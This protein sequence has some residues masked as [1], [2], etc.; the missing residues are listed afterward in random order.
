MVGNH[1]D[2]R[3]LATLTTEHLP[4][5]AQR[6]AALDVSV[7]LLT[8]RWFL[9][10]WSS[11]LPA[12][13]LS[14]LW[15]FLFV[16]GPQAT[17]QA[18]L[19]CM[20]LVEQPVLASRD[21]GEALAAVKEGL[22]LAADGT[23]LMRVALSRVAQVPRAQLLA[24]R[25]HCRQKVISEARHVQATR[26]LL[27]LQRSSG[28]SLEELKLMARLSGPFTLTPID[29]ATALLRI[30]LDYDAFVG[31]LKGLVPQW[32]NDGVPALALAN[33]GA[34]GGGNGSGSGSS[35]SGSG[36]GAAAAASLMRRLFCLF[37]A[38][39]ADGR[40]EVD[41]DCDRRDGRHEVDID[42]DRRDGLDAL[43]HIQSAEY[44]V[45]G[46][47]EPSATRSAAPASDAE[48]APPP[49]QRLSFEQL[50]HGLS[51]LLRGTSET[52][53]QLCFRA[54][55]QAAATPE[56]RLP[57]AAGTVG[58]ERFREILT[59]V[60]VMYEPAWPVSAEAMG[61][62]GAEA[63]QFTEIAFEL[64]DAQH[65]AALDAEGF[66]RAAH[67]HPL[68]VQAFQLEQLDMPPSASRQPSAFGAAHLRATHGVYLGMRPGLVS[69]LDDSYF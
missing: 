19:A 52:R 5:L 57:A 23:E 38:L 62:I 18:A 40:H 10:L 48:P 2:C 61:R 54:F 58:R 27:K 28:F 43:P 68:L 31:V 60:Y 36:G 21:I 16:T 50:V 9:C 39:P 47:A 29:A 44:A 42:C 17:M 8:T 55:E 56:G 3:V 51:W 25:L 1:I 20:H 7:Q 26:R 24:W 66:N 63:A 4:R 65:S 46:R 22:R 33:G 59:S 30:T 67:Q 32:K 37:V 41:I 11:V 14:R 15:D 69:R 53:A 49:E 45:G 12:A 64:W 6:L 35:S 34:D 13:A